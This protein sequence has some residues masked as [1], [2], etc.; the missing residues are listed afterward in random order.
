MRCNQ[1][2]IKAERRHLLVEWNGIE[3]GASQAQLVCQLFEKQVDCTPDAVAAGFK[4]ERVSYLE[5]DRR[6]NQLANYLRRHGVGPEVMVGIY[7]ERSLGVLISIL[8]VLKAGG[9]YVPLDPAYPSKQIQFMTEETQAS[10]ILTQEKLASTLS[11][12]GER[13]ICLDTDWRWIAAE[14]AVR[15]D[16]QV[17]PQN[18]AYAIFTSGSTGKPKAVMISHKSLANYAHT[19]SRE[20]GLQS[21]DRFLQLASISFDVSVEEVIPALL[22]GATIVLLFEPPAPQDFLQIVNQDMATIF[23]IPTEFW[24]EWVRELTESAEGLPEFVR[25]VI[26]GGEPTLPKMATIWHKVA[27]GRDCLMNVYGLTETTVTSTTYRPTGEWLMKGLPIGKPL[28]NS[29]VYILDDEMMLAPV[30]VA[31]EIYIGGETVAR[32]YLRQPALSAERFVPSPYS[33]SGGMR[34]YKTDDIG[35]FARDGNIEILGR[36]D[37]QIKIRGYRIEPGEVEAAL[38]QHQGIRQSLV[39]SHTDQKGD[40]KLIACVV[41]RDGYSLTRR[42][43]RNHLE[44]RLPGYMVP[45]SFVALDGLPLTPTGKIDRRAIPELWQSAISS[46][47][48]FI[49]PAT[50]VEE[51][52]AAIWAEV[53]GVDRVGVSDNFFEMGGHSLLAMRVIS[54]TRKAFDTEVPLHYIFKMPTVR[55]LAKVIVKLQGISRDSGGELFMEVRAEDPEQLLAALDNLSDEQVD[56]LLRNLLTAK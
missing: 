5:L 47:Q 36:N 19:I 23:E 48:E 10:V 37:Q 16:C 50:E 39:V 38:Q 9:A 49:A 51:K 44:E 29:R 30:G 14:S 24:H 34:L 28:Q 22:N 35:R 6:A 32:G 18:L 2:L 41:A 1:S 31:G 46:E 26:I 25:L 56:S 17:D 7:L 15:P 53:L 42:E 3:S 12:N 40:K 55:G 21:T 43:L 45:N 54:L 11:A 20:F 33:E 13:I 4:G 27:G 8:G 52:L